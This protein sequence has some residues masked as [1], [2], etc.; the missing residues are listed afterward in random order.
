MNMR[1][2]RK[3]WVEDALLNEASTWSLLRALARRAGAGHAAGKP[4]GVRLDG[5]GRLEEVELG[6]GWLDVYPE[7]DPPF[8]SM[9][10]LPPAI[11]DMLKLY[12]PLCLG[13]E[14]TT[15]KDWSS[16]D[17]YEGRSIYG[18]ASPCRGI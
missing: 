2:I 7:A 3:V 8:Q 5:A 14:S 16:H 1:S 15:L 11:D 17:W 10:V 12:L 6:M 4:C 13:P 18:N 9:V